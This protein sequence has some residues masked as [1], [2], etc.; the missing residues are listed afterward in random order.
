MKTIFQTIKNPL[1]LMSLFVFT[2]ACKKDDD[3]TSTPPPP[4]NE[5]EIITTATLTFTDVSGAEPSFTATFR[6]PDGDGGSGPDIFDTIRLRDSTVYFVS[7]TLLDET[8]NPAEDITEEVK[9][10]GDEHRVCYTPSTVNVDIDLT[11]T[12]GTHPIGIESGWTTGAAGN[13]SVRVTLKHQPGIKDGSCTPGETDV[14]IT[15]VTEVQ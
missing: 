15:F 11:D 9:E 14:D 12:D 4:T 1:I 3:K 13:G 2:I 8:K 7:L 6:D 5:S 10:E